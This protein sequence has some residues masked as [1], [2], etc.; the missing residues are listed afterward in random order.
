MTDARKH[1]EL[2]WH[3]STCV[4]CQAFK[5]K[6]RPTKWTIYGSTCAIDLREPNLGSAATAQLPAVI[7][8]QQSCRNGHVD[9][10]AVGLEQSFL[11]QQYTST[12][13]CA[14]RNVYTTNACLWER[15]ATEQYLLQTFK[16]RTSIASVILY[17]TTCSSRSAQRSSPTERPELSSA[18]LTG[19][20]RILDTQ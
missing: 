4:S 19:A 16:W 15:T 10:Q 1:S 3:P 13:P 6:Y 11:Q 7:I 20:S 18:H 12:I 8:R 14:R 9:C 5:L 17:A 2:L